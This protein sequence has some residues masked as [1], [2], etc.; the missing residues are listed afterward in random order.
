MSNYDEIAE[1][2]AA[3]EAQKLKNEVV[4][5]KGFLDYF[6]IALTTC[7]VGYLPVAPG[8]WGSLVGVAI[9]LL[10]WL[11][12]TKLGIYFLHKSWSAEQITAWIHAV[13]V[14]ILLVFCLVGVWASGRAAEIFQDKDP[15]KIVVDEVMG[16]LLVFMFIP[17]DVHWYYVVAG[18]LLFRL[19]DI[20]KP[21]PI[22]A[23]QNLPAGIGICADD[24]LAGV[25]AGTCLVLLYAVK[26]SL[27]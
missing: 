20:W 17:F 19:F 2:S 10:F 16:Q 24:I 25:Y 5:N 12:E 18:F 4:R 3:I 14:I 6:S 15:G 8:T 26:L 27:F 22:D 9:Y 11:I 13:N 7:G 1:I 21:Y 23:L